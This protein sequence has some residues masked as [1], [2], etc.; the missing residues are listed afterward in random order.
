VTGPPATD[1]DRFTDEWCGA[2]HEF[3][4]R[5]PSATDYEIGLLTARR[6]LAAERARSKGLDLSEPEISALYALAIV[7]PADRRSPLED[8][9]VDKLRAVLER[10]GG[11]PDER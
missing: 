2:W 11:N 3:K 5:K 8:A 7:T 10:P 9:A 4:V 1:Q 6:L